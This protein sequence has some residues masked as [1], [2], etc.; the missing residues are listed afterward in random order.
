MA[1]HQVYFSLG[2]NLGDRMEHLREGMKALSSKLKFVAASSVFETE[3]WGYADDLPYL[4]IAAWFETDLNAHNLRKLCA[5]IEKASGRFVKTNPKLSDYQSRT[6]DI[7]ILFFD[8]QQIEDFDLQIPHPRL[9]L[10]NF[11]LFPLAEING[12][13]WHPVLGKT[14][15][16]LL[17]STADTS[18]IKRFAR[19]I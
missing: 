17:S 14:I 7:D 1:Q 3:P 4:N 18:E 19:S 13:L 12:G 8:Q 11:V 5:E 15:K 9:H 10:R 6:L 2:S 16:E